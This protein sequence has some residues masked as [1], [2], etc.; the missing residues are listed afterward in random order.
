MERLPLREGMISDHLAYLPERD[1]LRRSMAVQYSGL[2]L[3][4]VR[5]RHVVRIRRN[6]GV[7]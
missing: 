2:D 7:L 6:F 3:S 5:L 4:D 1:L